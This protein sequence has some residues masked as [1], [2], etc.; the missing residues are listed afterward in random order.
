MNREKKLIDDDIIQQDSLLTQILYKTVGHIE[1]TVIF[2][3]PPWHDCNSAGQQAT[4][5][6]LNYPTEGIL[7]VC[8]IQ[9]CST[10][11]CL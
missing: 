9:I 7:L 10:S 11:T 8:L 2:N 6:W 1:L 3:R 5:S 4:S